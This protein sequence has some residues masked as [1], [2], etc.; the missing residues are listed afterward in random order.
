MEKESS[1]DESG[2]ACYMVQGNDS[3]EVNSDTQPDDSAS[4]SGD[5][6]M[7]V[8]ALNEELSLFC[9]N[10]VSYTHLTLPTKRIV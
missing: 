9:E 8:D 5:D 1:E 4:S 10:S 3:L 7:D 2:Q 6:N